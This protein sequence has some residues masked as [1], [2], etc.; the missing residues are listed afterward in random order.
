MPR[1]TSNR[2]LYNSCTSLPISTIHNSSLSRGTYPVLHRL[3]VLPCYARIRTVRLTL[4]GQDQ[5]S[6]IYSYQF[7]WNTLKEVTHSQASPDV[8]YIYKKTPEFVLPL[9]PDP[10]PFQFLLLAS[11]LWCISIY[12]REG[13]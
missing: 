10:S 8:W 9:I 4:N 3:S 12:T 13:K 1:P 5:F 11:F 7:V 2:F 6:S